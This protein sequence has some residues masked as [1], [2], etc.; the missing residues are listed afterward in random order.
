MKKLYVLLLLL[1]LA[2]PLG[3][4]S[5]NPAWGEWETEFFK[6]AIGYIPFGIA[7]TS[8]PVKPL[9][10]DYS[11]PGFSSIVSYYLSALFGVL[12]IFVS[13]HLLYRVS[14]RNRP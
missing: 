7:H 9:I 8:S 12:L 5:Q 4:I 2:T 14:G 1:I 10:P 11:L 13:F 6:K 3:L